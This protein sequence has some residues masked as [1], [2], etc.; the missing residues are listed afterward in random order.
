MDAEA[1]LQAELS[2]LFALD[3]Q[4]YLQVYL[5]TVQQL[6]ESTWRE[7]VQQAYRA[8]HTIK[9]GAATVGA[10]AILRAAT[11]LEDLLSE[12]RYREQAPLLSDGE[13][14]QALMEGGELL[15]GSLELTDSRAVAPLVQRLEA[16]HIFVKERYLAD[17][18]EAVILQK[19]F[20]ENGFDLVILDLDIALENLEADLPPGIQNVATQ[21]LA[22]LKEIGQELAMKP[23]WFTAIAVAEQVC[24]NADA[25]V[26]REFYSEFLPRLKQC[27]RRGGLMSEGVPAV[28]T[29]PT[30][31]SPDSGRQEPLASVPPAPA[32][33]VPMAMPTADRFVVELAGSEEDAELRQLFAIDTQKDLQNYFGTLQQI[34]DLPWKGAIQQLYRAIHTIKG[35]AATVGAEAI[36]KVAAALEEIL[37]DLRYL[38]DAPPLT[39]GNLQQVLLEGG[40]LL[41]GA[42]AVSEVP[43]TSVQ[44]LEALRE[45]VKTSYLTGIDEQVQLWQ[46]FADQGF[47][48]VILSL[49]MGLEELTPGTPVPPSLPEVATATLAQLREIGAELEMAAGWE[50]LLQKGEQAIAHPQS[51]AWM[52]FWPSYLQEL[53][54]C[55]RKGGKLA[56][57]PPVPSTPPA[58]APRPAEAK[59][60][61]KP[62]SK[63][64]LEVSQADV[65]IAVPLERLER[66]SQYLVETLMATRATEGFYQEVQANL[67]PLVAL[68]QDSIQYIAQLREVQDDY[69]LV[70]ANKNRDGGLQV[71]RYR[72]GYTAINRL[73]EISLRLVEL[74]AETGEAARR[75]ADSLTKLDRSLRGL[76]QTIEESRLVP[77]E[78]LAF[79]TRG[80]LRDLTTRANKPAQLFVTGDKTE[81]DAGTLRNLEPVLLH[82]VRNSFDHGLEAPEDRVR[83]GKPERGRI[84][85]SLARRGS[86]FVLDIADDGRGIDRAKIARIATEKGLPLTDTSTDEKL[87]AVICQ[88]GFTSAQA[89]S[90]I[91]GRGVGMDVVASQIA[92]LGGQLSLSTQLGQGTR[93]RMQLPVPHLFVRCTLL[94]AGNRLFA[95][96]AS[97]VFTMVLLDDLLVEEVTNPQLPYRQT[98]VEDTGAV[99]ALDLLSYWQGDEQGRTLLPN[100]V[101]VRT[102]QAIGTD[103]IWLLADS[104]YG[105]NDL[106]VNALPPPLTP[107][108]GILGTS[109]LADGRLVPVI[110]AAALIEVVLHTPE[111]A[112]G[113]LWR[114]P[115]AVAASGGTSDSDRILVVDDAAL[116][117]RRLEGSLTA[118]GYNVR[119]CS[120]GQEAWE[121]LQVNELPA[122]ILTDIEMP[123]MDGF[124]L[125]DRCRQAG[126]TMPIVVVSSRLAEEW[127]Q[128]TSRLGATDYLTKGFSTNDLLNKVAQ[129]FQGVNRA[130]TV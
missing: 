100:S 117:R 69:A 38:D 39:D 57:T 8:I 109:L 32:E 124:T 102:K 103:G 24:Q 91:S 76:Q 3:T 26:W 13:L 106:L 55:A 119:T 97:E 89:V 56:P 90:D 5:A 81:L 4:K 129:Y 58:I 41:L 37:S 59:P 45:E 53:K 21:V 112:Q 47:D 60:S 75:T 116:M 27:A 51:D 107:P 46:E 15:V 44:R 61:S 126:M 93:F 86:V 12:M 64:A 105:Q 114:L 10:E 92:A 62:A 125:I 110:D 88:S 23:D 54:A 40:E 28:P 115:Q 29:T 22:Q 9:G 2:Q 72:Q 63:P 101:A 94:Q 111:R 128:E 36:L 49:E 16:L 14:Q 123:R 67:L 70:D 108:I 78:T 113:T 87:L 31:G 35:G 33:S 99:P 104:I 74:G 96:P 20:A 98:V 48:L 122:L 68:A 30:T 34:L 130:A 83:L 7:D 80:I 79:R 42:L 77:F 6:Q 85:L 118:K 17:V 50:Q 71:E 127:S 18:S 84:D 11:V 65:Q 25:A 82:L 19:D 121:W 73:L 1:E 95:V 43:W 120:D 52:Q 66:S